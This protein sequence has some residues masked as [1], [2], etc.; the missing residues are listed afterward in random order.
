MNTRLV[1]S[2]VASYLNTTLQ[3]GFGKQSTGGGELK[4]IGSETEGDP[5]PKDKRKKVKT[6]NNAADMRK[7]YNA[8]NDGRKT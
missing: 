5:T 4:S 2:Q 7:S 6:P 8:S 1:K 3:S